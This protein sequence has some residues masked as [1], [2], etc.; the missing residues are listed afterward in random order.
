MAWPFLPQ[1]RDRLTAPRRPSP[2][3]TRREEPWQGAAHRPGQGKQVSEP[4]GREPD[5]GGHPGVVCP[6][7]PFTA[8]YALVTRNYVETYSRSIKKKAMA[9]R[10]APAETVRG[11]AWRCASVGASARQTP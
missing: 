8:P 7:C 3:M 9:F 2:I 11:P 10:P 6:M 1:E 5:S 4:L